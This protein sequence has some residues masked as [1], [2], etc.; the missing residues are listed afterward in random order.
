MYDFWKKNLPGQVFGLTRS[1]LLQISM[2][3]A[4]LTKR[5]KLKFGLIMKVLHVAIILKNIL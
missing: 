5:E 3:L 1:I 4:I 2:L